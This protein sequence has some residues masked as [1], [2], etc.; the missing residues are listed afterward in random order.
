MGEL[1]KESSREASTGVVLASRPGP[2]R[3]GVLTNSLQPRM[4]RCFPKVLEVPLPPI[5]PGFPFPV[6]LV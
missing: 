3:G 2:P 5:E 6:S 1:G 4:H